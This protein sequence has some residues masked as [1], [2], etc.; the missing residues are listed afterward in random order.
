MCFFDILQFP[1]KIQ[2]LQRFI[3]LF[4][5]TY[6]NLALTFLPIRV[7][8]SANHQTVNLPTVNNIIYRIVQLGSTYFESNKYSLGP[9]SEG[10][11]VNIL[12]LI[13]LGFVAPIIWGKIVRVRYIL[14]IGVFVS[15]TSQFLKFLGYR[16]GSLKMNTNIRGIF[17]SVLGVFIGRIIYRILSRIAKF[18]SIGYPGKL[19]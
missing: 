8:N 17:Y 9:L 14:F 5:I 1:R 18:I 2:I 7:D 16:C 6:I 10:G 3:G 13:P 15:I 4:R 11:A 12:I 19:L